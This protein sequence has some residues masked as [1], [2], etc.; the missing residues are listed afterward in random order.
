MSSKLIHPEV[1]V[2]SL[3]L[4]LNIIRYNTYFNTAEKKVGKPLIN[5]KK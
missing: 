3:F 5:A 2:K 4:W 1:F